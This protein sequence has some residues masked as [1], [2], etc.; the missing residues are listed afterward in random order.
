M[1]GFIFLFAKLYKKIISKK[2]TGQNT[3]KTYILVIKSF[4]N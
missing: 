4:F 2:L 1:Y 3:K